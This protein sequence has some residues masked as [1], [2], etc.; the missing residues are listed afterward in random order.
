MLW[1]RKKKY[2][3]ELEHSIYQSQL[4]PYIEESLLFL[5]QVSSG[6]MFFT[7]F[8]R[9]EKIEKQYRIVLDTD[10]D[11]I[12]KNIRFRLF[13]KEWRE[14][15]SIRKTRWNYQLLLRLPLEHTNHLQTIDITHTKMYEEFKK[16]IERIFRSSE[17]KTFKREQT[18]KILEKDKHRYRLRNILK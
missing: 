5:K 18:L 11:L 2:D 15:I 1:K 17:D 6:E 7:G 10:D 8:E 16:E 14:I 3:T 12:R 13:A 4:F 9:F